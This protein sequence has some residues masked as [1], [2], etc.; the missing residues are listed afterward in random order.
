LS[1]CFRF[2]STLLPTSPL[3]RATLSLHH[4]TKFVPPSHQ[5]ARKF[6]NASHRVMIPSLVCHLLLVNLPHLS[7]GVSL[8]LL[9][10]PMRLVLAS[11][12]RTTTST[13]SLRHCLHAHPLPSPRRCRDKSSGHRHLSPTVRRNV[14]KHIT[15]CLDQRFVFLLRRLS[16]LAT[17]KHSGHSSTPGSRDS[18]TTPVL[19]VDLTISSM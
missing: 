8:P 2:R 6:S 11:P 10:W 7:S 5:H 3:T 9:L 4:H 19:Y 1:R 18:I 12:L 17:S 16:F 15:W 14:K 13:L